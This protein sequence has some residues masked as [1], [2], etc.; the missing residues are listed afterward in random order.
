M[1]LK[2]F[3]LVFI[4]AA[5]VLATWMG[6]WCLGLYRRVDGGWTLAGTVAAFLAAAALAL[7]GAAF[8]QKAKRL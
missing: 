3:H 1:S 5:A 6:F 4:A 8:W 7:Y 2:G